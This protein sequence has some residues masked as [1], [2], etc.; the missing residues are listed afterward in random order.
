VSG[1]EIVVRSLQKLLTE[2]NHRISTYFRSSAEISGNK[3][4]MAKAFFTGIYN[5]SSKQ[6]V[7]HLIRTQKPDIVHIHN[8]FPLISPS[9]LGECRRA[10]VPIVM[11]VHNYRLVCPNGLHM[12]KGVVCERCNNG[13]E[14]NCVINRCEGSLLK[15]TGYAIRNAV[16]RKMKLF[17]RNVTLYAALTDFQ[18]SKLVRAGFPADRISVLPNMIH[19][20]TPASEELGNWVGYVGRV[21]REKGIETLLAAAAKL[22]HIEFRI[23]GAYDRMS[24]LLDGAPENVKFVGHLNSEELPSFYRRSRMIVLCSTWFEGFPTVI[25]EAKMHGKPVICSRIGGLP[26]IVDD[27]RTGLLFT[28][29]NEHELAEHIQTLWSDPRRCM[30]MGASG[31]EKAIREYSADRYYQRLVHIYERAIELR[32]HL[33]SP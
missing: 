21:S 10:G 12:T 24:H 19:S 33:L 23:A 18:K 31:R 15:S 2:R 4:G 29:G 16:A 22:P 8:V 20:T 5:V 32:P 25:T 14:W 28:P 9:V 30:E 27:G 3:L 11:T 26:E 1:E 13:R 6:Q 17:H 7:R